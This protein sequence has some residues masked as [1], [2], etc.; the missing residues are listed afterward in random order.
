MPLHKS[1][2]TNAYS[3]KAIEKAVS[4]FHVSNNFLGEKFTLTPRIPR[5]PFVG[6]GQ[7]IIEDT[8]TPRV[9]LAPSLYRSLVAVGGGTANSFVY[10]VPNDLEVVV[11]WRDKR[12]RSPGN[13][14]GENFNLTEYLDWIEKKGYEEPTP[15]EIKGLFWHLVP[16]AKTT[17]ELWSLK[18]VP[19]V[20]LGQIQYDEFYLA[21][22][23]VERAKELQISSRTR[24]NKMTS[25]V[26]DYLEG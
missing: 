8:I 25:T 19:V 12:P 24:P 3:L 6:K 1:I 14:Y 16:D 18:P 21:K 5:Y 2:S 22:W 13:P 7:A 20:L 10:G 11:P 23:I 17:G 9:S 26:L 15:Q 4:L